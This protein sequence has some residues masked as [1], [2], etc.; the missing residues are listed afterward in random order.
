M[1]GSEK[2]SNSSDAIAKS[3]QPI[4]NTPKTAPTFTGGQDEID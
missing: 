3:I 2:K 4:I 1:L